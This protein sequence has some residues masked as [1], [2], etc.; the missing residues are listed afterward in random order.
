MQGLWPVLGGNHTDA[1]AWQALDAAVRDSLASAIPAAMQPH[2]EAQREAAA[3]AA[4]E[5][6]AKDAETWFPYDTNK[7]YPSF[8]VVES[9]RAIDPAQF[10]EVGNA[11]SD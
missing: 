1:D 8:G 5:A 2:I 9:I 4:L 7:R 3:R 11:T 6:A 10:R